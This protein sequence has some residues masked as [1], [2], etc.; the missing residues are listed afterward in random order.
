[1]NLCNIRQN[2]SPPEDLNDHQKTSKK[3]GVIFLKDGK[4]FFV[5]N[6]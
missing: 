3:G 1:M 4:G 6:D 2:R 5:M